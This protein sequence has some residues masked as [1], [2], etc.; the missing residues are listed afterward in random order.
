MMNYNCYEGGKKTVQ[1]QIRNNKTAKD[2]EL[3]I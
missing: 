3:E 2:G 1:V